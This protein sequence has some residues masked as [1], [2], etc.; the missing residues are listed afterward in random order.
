[1]MD[2]KKAYQSIYTGD[3]EL[4]LRR[5]LYRMD[6]GDEWEDLAFTRATFGDVSAGLV[7]EVAKR[8]V[9]ELG[10]EVDPVAAQQLADYSYIGDNLMGGSPEDVAR[11]RGER[12]NGEYTGTVPRI[13]SRGAMKVKFMAVSGSSNQWEVEQLAGKTLGVQYRLEQDEIYFVLRPGYY[14]DKQKSSDQVREIVLLDQPQV[15]AL[16][17]GSRKLMRRQVLSMVMGLYDP[18]GLISPTL[19]RG[20]LLLRRLY[21]NKA[22]GGWDHDMPQEEKV[23]W[24]DWFDELLVPAEASFPRST[25]PEDAVGLPTAQVGGVWRLVHGCLVCGRLCGVERQSRKAASSSTCREVS[26]LS[27]VWNHYTQR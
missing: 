18:L 14:G 27:A 6:P 2:L 12:V 10:Q 24:A 19:T 9:A 21:G 17:A 4:H 22:V 20:K 11:M 15:D 16:R 5:F 26:C 25:R 1:M 3:M 23:R 7:L 8:R 13:L